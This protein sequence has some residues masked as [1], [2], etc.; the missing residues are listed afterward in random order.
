MAAISRRASNSAAMVR[1]YAVFPAPGVATSRKSR[2]GMRKYSSYAS[3]C[4]LRKDKTKSGLTEASRQLPSSCVAD[5]GVLT[6]PR[7]YQRWPTAAAPPRRL[8]SGRVG[9]GAHRAVEGDRGGRRV[10]AV[11]GADE[12]DVRGVAA[13]GRQ[14]AVPAQVGHLDA[15]PASGPVA[16]PAGAERLRGSR[17]RESERP[18]VD[19][20]RPGVGDADVGDVAVAPPLGHVIRHRAGTV[21]WGAGGE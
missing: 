15:L 18:A 5:A 20:V 17:E 9:G 6:G 14:P 8:G 16:V 3:R 11:V 13:V 7:G 4:Q 10:G 12:A 19:G 2:L 1:A 21:A